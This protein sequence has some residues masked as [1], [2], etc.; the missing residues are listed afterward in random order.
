MTSPQNNDKFTEEVIQLQEKMTSGEIS[1]AEFK[2]Q[3]EELKTKYGHGEAKKEEKVTFKVKSEEKKDPDE[4][5]EAKVIE[6][7]KDYKRQSTYSL[8]EIE[9]KI[10]RLD[11][12]GVS[13]LRDRYKDKYGEDLMVPD[14]HT[15]NVRIALEDVKDYV[16]VDEVVEKDDAPDSEP[17]EEEPEEEKDNGP[18]FF[19]QLIAKIKAFFAKLFSKKNKEPAPEEAVAAGE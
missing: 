7:P 12:K 15:E 9:K 2:T 17:V 10:D 4:I 11:S 6:V 13:S 16:D 3:L 19:A 8:H 14:L 18:G 1:E 5:K